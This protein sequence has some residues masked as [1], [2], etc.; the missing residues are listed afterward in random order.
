[1]LVTRYK[2]YVPLVL[3]WRRFVAASLMWRG[4]D[5]AGAKVAAAEVLEDLAFVL[6]EAVNRR[7]PE[8]PSEIVTADR[9]H[10]WIKA[11]AGV[12][13]PD[14][15][16]WPLLTM[17]GSLVVPGEQPMDPQDEHLRTRG[18]LPAEEVGEHLRV[19]SPIVKPGDWMKPPYEVAWS[20]AQAL[21]LQSQADAA[22]PQP[23][24]Q[25]RFEQALGVAKVTQAVLR[26]EAQDAD[27]T[28]HLLLGYIALR[29]PDALAIHPRALVTESVKQLWDVD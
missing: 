20:R 7:D 28:V 17:N 12:Y 10:S 9:A 22:Q 3:K 2:A 16:R 4:R 23:S 15:D 19:G 25:G 8:T 27:G 11:S 14:P 18:W 5:A 1:M 24:P 29:R 21:D 26:L 6:T 13:G